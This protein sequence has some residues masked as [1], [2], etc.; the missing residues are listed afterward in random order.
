MIP[1]S[2]ITNQPLDIN[3]KSRSK[4]TYLPKIS[5]KMLNA[6]IGS[7]LGLGVVTG[8]V[9]LMLER[10][11][12]HQIMLP[13]LHNI[14]GIISVPDLKIIQPKY[15]H[16]LFELHNMRGMLFGVGL[17]NTML[18]NTINDDNQKQAKN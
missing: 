16:M 4:H 11:Q 9:E 18:A 15:Q 3:T 10:Q 12:K 8:L 2:T 7:G 13:E 14:R 5:R 6:T 17:A 1:K